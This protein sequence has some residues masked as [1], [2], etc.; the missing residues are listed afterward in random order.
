MYTR[1][2]VIAISDNAEVFINFIFSRAF[3]RVKMAKRES[4][5][6]YGISTLLYRAYKSRNL[7]IR[8][9]TTEINFRYVLPPGRRMQSYREEYTLIVL[10]YKLNY[11]IR[12]LLFYLW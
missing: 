5:R 7:V 8:P 11:R 2:R 10:R 6:K 4:A 12:R 9:R 3:R 1:V